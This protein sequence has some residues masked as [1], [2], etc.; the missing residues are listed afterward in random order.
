MSEPVLKTYT[1]G[2]KLWLLSGMLHRTD[3][4]A[5]IYP[6]GYKEWWL[7]NY[8]MPFEEWCKK[9]KKTDEEIALL[10]LEYM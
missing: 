8:L 5:A 7:N 6:D 3:G 2:T 10:K 4:P 1:D 9:T